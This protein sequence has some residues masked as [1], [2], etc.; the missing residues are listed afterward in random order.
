[1]TLK[2]T[3][4]LYVEPLVHKLTAQGY[5]AQIRSVSY[6]LRRGENPMLP[7]KKHPN[8]WRDKPVWGGRMAVRFVE[9][10]R[11]ACEGLRLAESGHHP[12]NTALLSAP[13]GIECPGRGPVYGHNVKHAASAF[14][15]EKEVTAQMQ[16]HDKYTGTLADVLLPDGV[17]LIQE[18]VR[19]GRCWWY[20]KHAPRDTVLTG[21][22]TEAREVRKGLGRPLDGAA[23]G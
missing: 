19:R 8:Q 10:S 3:P 23:V 4:L 15:F 17:N 7:I 11:R 22:E 18:L 21:L 12:T 5:L 1:M 16:G 14:A 20:R 9:G 2:P 6:E 13:R